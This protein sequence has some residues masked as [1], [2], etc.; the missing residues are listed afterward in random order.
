MT[1]SWVAHR[2]L[3]TT[4][5]DADDDAAA[6]ADADNDDGEV[7]SSVARRGEVVMVRA[8]MVVMTVRL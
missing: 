6:D 2:C 3:E 8:M 7:S 1:C 4:E 5:D